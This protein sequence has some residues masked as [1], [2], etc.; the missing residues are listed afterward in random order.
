[1]DKPVYIYPPKGYKMPKGKENW[2]WKLLK[3]VYGLKQAS[4][5]WWGTFARYVAEELG[6]QEVHVES[7]IFIRRDGDIITILKVYVDDF[8]LA[9][10]NKEKFNEI[11][12]RLVEKF[13]VKELPLWNRFLGVNVTQTSCDKC[14]VYSSKT[15]KKKRPSLTSSINN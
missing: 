1:M 2:V 7:C 11:K 10:T 15:L 14:V 8:I 6:F 4:R 9:S 12:S 13:K 3:C 5:M